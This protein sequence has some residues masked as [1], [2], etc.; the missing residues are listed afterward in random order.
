MRVYGIMMLL[1]IMAVSGCSSPE[2]KPQP[3]PNLEV[4]RIKQ[5]TDREIRHLERSVDK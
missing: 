5:A 1:S 2:P 4:E 3:D